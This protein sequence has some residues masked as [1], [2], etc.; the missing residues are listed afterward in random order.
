MQHIFSFF[1]SRRVR[2]MTEAHASG[3]ANRIS[4]LRALSIVLGF[5][6]A[7]P[8]HAGRPLTTDDAAVFDAG[9]CQLETW[10]E[11]TRDSSS[12]W[13]NP[14]CNPFGS[15]EF[16]LGGARV[17]EDGESTLKVQHWQIKQL[18]HAYDETQVGFALAIGGQR[19]RNG[20]ARETFLN[21]IATLPLVGETQLLHLNLGVLRSKDDVLQRTRAI[22]GLAYDAELADSTR[23]SLETFGTAGE[24]VN[25]Q[26]GLR[27]EL[28][29]G[30]VQIDASV[31]S[32]LGRWSE[33]RIVTFGLV[34]VTPPFLR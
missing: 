26:L 14:A 7:L 12:N 29:P 19:E 1:A 11:R 22:W 32:A 25:W 17:R 9:A 3:A 18:L 16:A 8:A 2:L 21:G 30:H 31:G 27:H 20:N 34:F 33:T 10:V 4:A 6:I 23:A 15:T 24:R 13:I 5:A 28:I